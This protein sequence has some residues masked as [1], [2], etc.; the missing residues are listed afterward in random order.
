MSLVGYG[1]VREWRACQE[2]AKTQ[3][4]VENTHTKDG[5]LYNGQCDHPSRRK[6]RLTNITVQIRNA[7]IPGEV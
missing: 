4:G 2:S 5:L 6:F 7:S 3:I 1:Q